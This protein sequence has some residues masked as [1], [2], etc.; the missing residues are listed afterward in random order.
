MEQNEKY[1][2]VSASTRCSLS[3]E[4]RDS[5]PCR[6][7]SKGMEIGLW[8]RGARGWRRFSPPGSFPDVPSPPVPASEPVFWSEIRAT[9]SDSAILVFF[10]PFAGALAVRRR[11]WTPM[12]RFWRPREFVSTE[13][14]EERLNKPRIPRSWWPWGKKAQDQK[15]R[16]RQKR[17]KHKKIKIS[18]YREHNFFTKVVLLFIMTYWQALNLNEI[19]SK[20]NNA[21]LLYAFPTDGTH[22]LS[23][24]RTHTKQEATVDYA[25]TLAQHMV[26]SFLKM[27]QQL[28]INDLRSQLFELLVCHT[29]TSIEKMAEH[30]VHFQIMHYYFMQ[31]HTPSR[32]S[33]YLVRS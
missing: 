33:G 10:R 3:G 21:M 25:C 15:W 31:H 17:H 29:Q 2:P 26:L 24:T 30:Q 5:C 23:T 19:C 18:T 28:N 16:G 14:L 27:R 22:P 12:E 4:Q 11:S 8:V 9:D 1:P 20:L 7:L 32:T 13:D 6:S